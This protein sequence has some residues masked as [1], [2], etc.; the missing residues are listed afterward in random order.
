MKVVLD[1]FYVLNKCLSIFYVSGNV[2]D[3]SDKIE[4]QQGPCPNKI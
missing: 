1:S 2:K 3:A 4:D